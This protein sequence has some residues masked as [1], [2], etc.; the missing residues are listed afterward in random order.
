M[1][2]WKETQKLKMQKKNLQYLAHKNQMKKEF[3]K[4]RGE[5]SS[6]ELRLRVCHLEALQEYKLLG[7]VL[8]FLIQSVLGRVHE[9]KSLTNS[10]VILFLLL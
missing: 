8:A 5:V 4:G 1:G 7:S 10:Q 9:F 3:Q 6:I 2:E